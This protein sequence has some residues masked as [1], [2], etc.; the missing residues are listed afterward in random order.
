[1]E[2]EHGNKIVMQV[3]RTQ[4]QHNKEDVMFRL[5]DNTGDVGTEN[6]TL[7]HGG[8]RQTDGREQAGIGKPESEVVAEKRQTATGT[9]EQESRSGTG[10]IGNQAEDLLERLSYVSEDTIWQ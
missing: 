2:T 9:G 7:P 4:L 8:R 6:K 3:F 10:R 1:V 5:A